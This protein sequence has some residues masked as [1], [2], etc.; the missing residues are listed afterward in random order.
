MAT[1]SEAFNAALELHA[2]G[3]LDEAGVLYGRILDVAPDHT[4][5]LYLAGTL[6]CQQSRFDEAR[7]LLERAVAFAPDLA[8]AHLNL[9]RLHARAE[10]WGAAARGSRRCLALDPGEAQ[11]WELLGMAERQAG[12]PEEAVAAFE[13]AHR[14]APQDTGIGE[15]LGLLLCERGQRHLEGQRNAAA[16]A[17]LARAARLLPFDDAMGFSLGAGLG[18]LGRSAEA[19]AVYERVL[20]WSPA[21]PRVLHNLG[22]AL[23]R[24]GRVNDSARTL[25]RAIAVD[26]DCSDPHEAL[27]ALF[28]RRDPAQAIVWSTRAL[29]LKLK[30]SGGPPSEPVPAAGGDVPQEQRTRDV[31]SFSLWGA[32]EVYCAGAIANARL[33]PAMLP[34]WTCRFYHDGTVPPHILAELASLGA[35]LVAMP[36][37][38]AARQGMFWRF[39]PADDPTV[40]RFLCRDCDS[41]PTAREIAAVEEWIASGLP[42]H[43]MR[44]H[45]MHMEPVMGGMWGGTAGLLP[46]MGPVIGHFVAS[47]TGHW[48]DQHFLAEW[49]WPRIARAALVHD[50]VHEGQ[51]RP[52]PTPPGR[53]AFDHVDGHVGAKLLNLVRLPP[54][55]GPDGAED[56]AEGDGRHGRLA[57]PAGDPHVGRSLSALGEW[58]E[59]ET[60]FCAGF[61]SAGDVALDTDAGIGAHALAFSRAVGTGGRVLAFE[62]SPGLFDCLARTLAT[63]GL[64]NAVARQ[65]SAMT[66]DPPSEAVDIDRLRLV[67]T[68]IRRTTIVRAGDPLDGPLARAIAERRPVLHLRIEDDAGAAGAFIRLRDLGYRL[69]WHIAPVF[70][71]GNRLGTVANPFPG[72]VTVNALGLPPGR[73]PPPLRSLVEIREPDAGWM[74]AAWRLTCDGR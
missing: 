45:V 74:D 73:E 7:P 52:F 14:I 50:G 1:I 20:A 23:T 11:A 37:G 5:T 54:M 4:Q 15:K 65:G 72:L 2:A 10:D 62:E 31:V 28:D 44:D 58:L 55:R 43:V 60:A 42:F 67:R 70:N 8:A 64:D 35:E 47:R 68:T 71:P 27:A 32:L 39:L 24:I 34:G 36:P 17:D 51:G 30:Q 33:M 16:V 48:N 38:S 66:W 19:A 25:R 46:P 57:H 69:W 21:E 9:A 61:L 53:P 13:R 40:R 63:N 12:R 29:E 26:P 3:R 49:L 41:R 18:E 56:R 6:M 22:V 59:I